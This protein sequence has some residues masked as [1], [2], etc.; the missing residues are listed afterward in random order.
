MFTAFSLVFLQAIR[1][2][3]MKKGGL[4]AYYARVFT[5]SSTYAGLSCRGCD[6]APSRLVHC[7]GGWPTH[8]LTAPPAEL[9][10]RLTSFLSK[11]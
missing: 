1:F 3:Y 5:F 8:S 10:C 9:L 4:L 6:C 2:E 11:P 7:A